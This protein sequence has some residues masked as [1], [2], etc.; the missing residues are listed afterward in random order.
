MFWPFENGIFQLFCKFLSD[1]VETVFRESKTEPSRPFKFKV[2][3]RKLFR[4][5]F[6]SD[7][8]IKN[9]YSE[10]FEREIFSFLQF[11]SDEV[12]TIFWKSEAKHKKL[13]KSKFGHRS[14]LRKWFW[15]FLELK[16]K[17]C[18]HLK[19]TWFSFL[20]IF[21]WRSWSNFLR[22]WGKTWK[23]FLN[24]NLVIRSF[25]ENGFEATLS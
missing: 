17:Y 10:H 15:T 8:R 2:G 20:Q 25:L 24:Q 12:E 14:F 18:G 9:E 21:D 22:K 11:L 19:I 4:K 5:W 7:L 6:W 13:F 1:K 3:H 16:N 23:T